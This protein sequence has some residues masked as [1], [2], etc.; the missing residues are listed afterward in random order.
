M[1]VFFRVKVKK[2]SKV[3]ILLFVFKVFVWGLKHTCSVR[4]LRVETR[5]ICVVRGVVNINKMC[6]FRIGLSTKT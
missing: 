1:T 4:V 2:T 3:A 5:T 6:V